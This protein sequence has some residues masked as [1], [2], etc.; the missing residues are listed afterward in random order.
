MWIRLVCLFSAQKYAADPES[1]LQGKNIDLDAV[2]EIEKNAC[3]PDPCRLIILPAIDTCPQ[4]PGDGLKPE[5]SI[6]ELR[7]NSSVVELTGKQ[8]R[9][10]A[11]RQIQRVLRRSSWYHV[12]DS[13]PSSFHQ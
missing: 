8:F 5:L 6:M 2:F 10:T 3:Q 7:V 4:L 11:S 12:W 1:Q 9:K 13:R